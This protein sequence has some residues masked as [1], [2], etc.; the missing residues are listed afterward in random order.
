MEF[1][2]SNNV[3]KLCIQAMALEERGESEE[4]RGLFLQA[5]DQATDDFEKFL[6][7]YYLARHQDN[8]RDRLKWHE[9]A[10]QFALRISDE[11]VSAAFPS[12]YTNIAKCYEDL[13]DLD[14]AKKN[15]ELAISFSDK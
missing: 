10:L 7:A 2:P 9:T 12:V 4:A 1:S 14:S 8:A 15:Y 3:V 11:A 6:T 13:N 5:W